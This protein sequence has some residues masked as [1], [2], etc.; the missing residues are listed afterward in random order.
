M[1]KRLY[2]DKIEQHAIEAASYFNKQVSEELPRVKTSSPRGSV[3]SQRSRAPKLHAASSRLHE[4]KTA[5]ERVALF[6][7]QTERK[8]ARTF[9]MRVNLL[10]LEMKQNQLNFNTNLN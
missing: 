6:E 1:R 8:R 9:A 7:K 2:D 3:K 4:T 10:E 5:A